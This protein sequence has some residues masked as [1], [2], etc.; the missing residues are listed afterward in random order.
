MINWNP[1]DLEK[2][3]YTRLPVQFKKRNQIIEWM[4]EWDL[5]IFDN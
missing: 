1:K 2:I 4:D 5:P 3:R